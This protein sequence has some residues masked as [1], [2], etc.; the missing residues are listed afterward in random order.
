[1]LE[2]EIKLEIHEVNKI[3]NICTNFRMDF[4]NLNKPKPQEPNNFNLREYLD[5]KDKSKNN[6]NVKDNN[7]D[8]G[9]QNNQNP[10]NKRWE[11]F[12]GKAPFSHI[13]EDP[14][15]VFNNNNNNNNNI[16]KNDIYN[17]KRNANNNNEGNKN[18][19]DNFVANTP[20]KKR[21]LG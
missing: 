17:K 13:N 12:G 18:L 14:F 2:A 9:N 16:N 10:E 3:M 1:M 5:P 21:R 15:D 19:L 7:K 8:N 20:C 4:D 11:R 6:N